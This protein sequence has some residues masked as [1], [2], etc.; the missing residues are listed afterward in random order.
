MKKDL[1]AKRKKAIEELFDNN[2]I[3][4]EKIKDSINAFKNENE[5][6]EAAVNAVFNNCPDNSDLSQ[7]LVKVI[8]LNNRYSA[9][10]TDW[11]PSKNNVDVLNMAKHINDINHAIDECIDKDKAIETIGIVSRLDAVYTT[12]DDDGNAVDS[13]LRQYNAPSFASKYCIWTWIDRETIDLPILDSYVAGMLYYINKA[14]PF[15]GSFGQEKIKKDY[16][17]FYK[18]YT[19]FVNAFL[20]N[21]TLSNKQIDEFLWQYAKSNKDSGLRI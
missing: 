15:T 8:V 5:A 12:K 13:V 4:S 1:K 14:K 2:G 9:G 11:I 10:L 18:V 21:T 17:F 19:D 6:Y 20:P 7:V 3:K 16:G